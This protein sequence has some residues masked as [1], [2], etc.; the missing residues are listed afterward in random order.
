MRR[1]IG[2]VELWH[3]LSLT[4]AGAAGAAATSL[5]AH[6][7]RRRGDGLRTTTD[8]LH[9]DPRVLEIAED[10]GGFGLW[11]LELESG[12]AFLSAGAA[13]LS[14][15]EPQATRTTARM[16]NDQVH[17]DDRAAA[18]QHV[19]ETT[20]TTG[21]FDVEFRVRML[22]GSYC[23]RRSRGRVITSGSTHTLV[24]AI[25]DVHSE[26]E[27]LDRLGQDAE[28]LARAEDVA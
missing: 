12:N 5:Y 16:L 28:R 19:L 6:L 21:G 22:D 10:A 1:L 26:R 13:R 25:I 2:R 11:A 17:P 14:G 27:M 3:L 20:R 15:F 18:E 8:L 7:R 23:W 9:S 4:A 24:G